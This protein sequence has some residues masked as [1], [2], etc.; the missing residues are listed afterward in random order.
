MCVL[1][2]SFGSKVRPR[3]FGC[4]A[5]DSAVLFMLWSRLLFYSVGFGV[6]RVQVV[7]SGFSVRLFC[8]VQAKTLCMW[9]CMY[10]LA[11]LVLVCRCDGD[12]ICVCHDMNW[13][14]GWVY[15]DSVNVE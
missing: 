10:F 4:V 11:A 14:S 12:V 1:Y 6:N 2:A 15:V 7:L 5:M 3:T 9:G 8:F 13:C